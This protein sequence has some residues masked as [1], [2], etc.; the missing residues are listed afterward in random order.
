[1]TEKETIQQNNNIHIK[2]DKFIKRRFMPNLLN[3]TPYESSLICL[4]S[5]TFLIPSIYAMYLKNPLGYLSF[6][7]FGASILFWFHPTHGWRRNL[8]FFMAKLCGVSYF[9]AA[10]Q[11]IH[12]PTPRKILYTTMSAY[13]MCFYTAN[14][15]HEK[16]YMKKI[17]HT[18]YISIWVFIVLYLSGNV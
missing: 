16:N 8:D 7:C 12:D 18:G 15:L 9:M 11:S 6:T 13:L 2:N 4:S 17:I 14:K 5:S 1:M 3:I 10:Y